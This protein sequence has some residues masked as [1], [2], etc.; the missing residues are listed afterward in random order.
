MTI[1]QASPDS[2]PM[3]KIDRKRLKLIFDAMRSKSI[4][5]IG[6]LMLDEYIWGKVERIIT[7]DKYYTQKGCTIPL[8]YYIA[9]ISHHNSVYD[10][11]IAE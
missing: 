8:Y 5:V 7:W 2:Y 4:M 11:G 10:I 6:D 9:G 3:L 1:K